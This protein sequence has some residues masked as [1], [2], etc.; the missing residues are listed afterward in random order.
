VARQN[1]SATAEPLKGVRW[2]SG[3]DRDYDPEPGSKSRGTDDGGN[4]CRKS[5]RS[6][7]GPGGRAPLLQPVQ[8]MNW[9]CEVGRGSAE[10]KRARAE[11]R[12]MPG[13][14]RGP[15]PSIIRISGW[16]EEVGW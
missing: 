1:G 2:H 13:P 9:R 6:A 8:R 16:D 10:R 7:L 15:G 12:E 11:E 5:Q 4:N 3:V 14:P